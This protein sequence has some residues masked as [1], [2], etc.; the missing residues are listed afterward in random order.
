MSA[1][2]HGY[3]HIV[4]QLRSLATRAVVQAIDDTGANQSVTVAAHAGRTRS[5]VPVHQQFGLSSHAPVKGAV[6]PIVALGGDPSDLVALPPANP[7]LSRVGGLAEGET[8]LYDAIGQQVYLQDGKIVR[9][10][11]ATEM[12]V[13][14]GGK[15]LLDITPQGATLNVDLQVNGKIAATGDVTAGNISVQK[16]PHDGVQPGSGITGAPQP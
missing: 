1:D 14:I 9:I 12:T 8:V 3:D 2:G 10:V 4:M 15:T 6:A 16:H 11:A 5:Q 7:S 13:E